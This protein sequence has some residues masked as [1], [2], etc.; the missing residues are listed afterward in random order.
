[1][2]KRH[3]RRGASMIQVQA[4]DSCAPARW[5]PRTVPIA[6]VLL[7]IAVFAPVRAFDFVS[8]DDIEYLAA[9]SNVAGGLTRDNARWAFEHAYEFTGGPLTWLSHML[10]AELFGADAGAHHLVNLGL[11]T[12]NAV[13]LYGLLLRATRDWGTST[14]V[15]VVFAV[16]PVQVESVAWISQRK[17]VLSTL[18]WF[19]ALHAY[20]WF[21]RSRRADAY[22]AVCAC[23]VAGLL[24]KPMVATLPLTLLLLDLWP[25]R[26]WQR[27]GP[28]LA[29]AGRLVL[30]KVPLLIL[31][32]ASL[33]AVLVS[34]L[35]VGAVSSLEDMPLTIRL[36]NACVSYASYLVKLVWPTGL[37]AY[38]PLPESIPPSLVL[39]ALALLLAL[40]LGAALWVT[41]AP[42][43]AVGW[44]WYLVTLL[45]VI[46]LVQV[47]G[48]AM[49]DRYMYV[50]SVGAVLAGVTAARLTAT[51]LRIPGGLQAACASIAIV[52][53]AVT[54]RHQVWTWENSLALWQHAVDVSP[55]NARAYSNLGSA[56]MEQRR[57][58]DAI[59]AYS[60]AVDIA[61][62][63]P[64]L[65]RNL[66]LAL[67]GNGYRQRALEEASESV[68]IDPGY[69]DGH[70]TLADILADEG[71]VV[72]AIRHYE[73]AIDLDGRAGL[74][75]INLAVALARQGRLAEAL[76]HA[77]AAVVRDPE[78]I[79]WRLVTAMILKDMK[80]YQDAAREFS[81][82]LAQDP[83]N[84]RAAAELAELAAAGVTDRPL[85]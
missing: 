84:G 18:W 65:R 85:R 77:R 7:T 55:A 35:D 83:K 57:W 4:V 36:K 46:G 60:R 11:H 27:D 14:I 53:F 28:L 74:P 67:L 31:S 58:D 63:A 39:G 47:G 52:L 76:P 1:M 22:L 26:R 70:A 30:E 13:L 69:A 68:R 37:T 2:G 59:A 19:G 17:D 56:F 73:T 29:I 50:P 24:S 61:P 78:H 42:A 75:R 82:V 3:S 15:A 23:H 62:M 72:A 41:R 43:I 33:S 44:A 66:A 8:Y 32:A 48:H 6:I 25:L 80:R 20:L 12:L 9:N 45:P 34:Q 16:H 40:T 38:Y 10:D 81:I 64:R 54:A 5:L 21:V 79:E 51:R 71:D 49:A